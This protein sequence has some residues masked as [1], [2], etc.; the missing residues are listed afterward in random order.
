LA[1]TIAVKRVISL[2]RSHTIVTERTKM[3]LAKSVVA[4]ASIVLLVLP[5]NVV[6][7]G[8][9]EDIERIHSYWNNPS[10]GFG[11][12]IKTGRL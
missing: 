4:I 2:S 1:R 12:S 9:Q 8:L 10:T 7:G 5:C 6:E 3:R 11:E